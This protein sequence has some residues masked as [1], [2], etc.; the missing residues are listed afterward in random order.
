MSGEDTRRLIFL[1]KEDT[2]EVE[3]VGD[4]NKAMVTAGGV[5][6]EEI[7]LRSYEVK[8]YPGMYI[9]GEALAI[10]GNTGGYN[11]Q[12]AFSSAWAAS[13]DLEKN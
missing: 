13:L 4:F 3:K 6:L 8:K 12:F 10:D 9:V 11:M 2:F 1:L 5:C 7:D